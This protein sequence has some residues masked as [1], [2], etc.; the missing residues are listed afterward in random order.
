[1]RRLQ[2]YL[3]PFLVGHHVPGPRA[4]VQRQMGTKLLWVDT[5]P[6]PTVPTY[7]PMCN[8]TSRCLNPPR[9]DKDVVLFNHAAAGVIAAAR[10]NGAVI[11]TA[12]LYSF[13]LSKCGGAG[14]VHCDGFQLPENVHYT[15][16]GWAALASRLAEYLFQHA[17][18]DG[19]KGR[20]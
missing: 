15:A 20:P 9:F 1:M 10:G 18:V 5:T 4:Q 3:S 19:D 12:D 14:Y 6:V 11:G 7:G 2:S 16:A 13:V 8:D 17:D